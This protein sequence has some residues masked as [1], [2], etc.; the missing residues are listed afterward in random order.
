M[1]DSGPLAERVEQVRASHHLHSLPRYAAASLAG[2]VTAQAVFALLYAMDTA[3][4][5][6]S[7]VAY[8][9]GAVPNYLINRHWAWRDRETTRPLGPYLVTMLTSLVFVTVLIDWIDG[10]IRT[11]NLS[12]GEQVVVATAAFL[13]VNGVAFLVKYVVLDRWVFA[14]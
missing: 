9:V 13:G 12:D 6:A 14:D 8:L 3:T 2:V 4:A 11:W 7:V 5:I 1:T 10:Y